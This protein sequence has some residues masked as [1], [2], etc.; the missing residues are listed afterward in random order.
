MY[1]MHSKSKVVLQGWWPNTSFGTENISSCSIL[2]K[3]YSEALGQGTMG[4]EKEHISCMIEKPRNILICLLASL[5][6][7][8]FVLFEFYKSKIINTE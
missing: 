1:R 8:I 7:V 5:F 3:I 6:C 4:I 2:P